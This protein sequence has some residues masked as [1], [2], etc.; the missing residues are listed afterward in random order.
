MVVFAI[1]IEHT[2]DVAIQRSH[3]TDARSFQQPIEVTP[4]NGVPKALTPRSEADRDGR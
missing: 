3:D 2:L 1:R 4:L